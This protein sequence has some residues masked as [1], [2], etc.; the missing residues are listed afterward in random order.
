MDS[1]PSALRERWTHICLYAESRGL[2]S[3]GCETDSPQR[4]PSHHRGIAGR[5]RDRLD[6]PGSAE[7]EEGRQRGPT[8]A[9]EGSPLRYLAG[10]GQAADNLLAHKTRTLLTARG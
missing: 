9:T 10:G 1:G 2:H 8:G 3:A 5:P 4:E 6:Q 7:H